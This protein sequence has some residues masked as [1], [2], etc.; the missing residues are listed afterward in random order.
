M[1]V[2]LLIALAIAS[3][4]LLAGTLPAGAVEG[5]I[6]IG[7]TSVS[8]PSPTFV[9]PVIQSTVVPCVSYQAPTAPGTNSIIANSITLGGP[10]LQTSITLFGPQTP[11][12]SP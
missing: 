8:V 5:I 6:G 3:I 10:A 11:S 9:A 1:R 12:F 7:S 2:K 4:L